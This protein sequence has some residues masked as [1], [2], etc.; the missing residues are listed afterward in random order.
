MVAGGGALVVAG[1]LVGWLVIR[2][3]RPRGSLITS[4]MIDDPRLPPRK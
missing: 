4:C 2:A 1:S 3:R